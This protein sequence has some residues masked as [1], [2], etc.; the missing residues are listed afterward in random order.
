MDISWNNYYRINT[1][2]SKTLFQSAKALGIPVFFASTIDVYGIQKDTTVDENTIPAPIGAYARSKLMAEH[3]LKEICEHSTYM[4]ARFAPIYSE[5][6]MK[7][8]QKRCYLKYPRVAYKIGN[9]TEYE[10]L[11]VEKAVEILLKWISKP[12]VAHNIINVRD[13]NRF[14]TNLLIKEERFNGNTKIIIRM[15]KSVVCIFKILIDILLPHNSFL[16][17]KFYKIIK[18]IETENA[19][20]TH[21]LKLS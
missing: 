20:M 17:F 1:M 7:D 14:D 21:F 15:P 5:N 18:P 11:S 9:G 3:A 10:F 6:N 12:A 13:E 8:I 16:K 2:C 4:I 19:K